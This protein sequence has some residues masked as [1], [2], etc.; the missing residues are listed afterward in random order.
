MGSTLRPTESEWRKQLLGYARLLSEKPSLPGGSALEAGTDRTFVFAG[1]YSTPATAKVVSI[2]V[3]E[4]QPMT[5]PEFLTLNP[6]GTTRPMTAT[7]DCS[8]GKPE[9]AT[10]SRFWEPRATSRPTSGR[11]QE[12]SS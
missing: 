12:R 7:I 3:A 11:G 10:P 1:Q 8:S 9:S 5:G 2:N 6:G 4:T